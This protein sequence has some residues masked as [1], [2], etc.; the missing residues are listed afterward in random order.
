MSD[1][2]SWSR[3]KSEIYSLLGRNPKS[4]R[5]V[6]EIASLEPTHVVLDVGCGPGAAVR[7]AAGSVARAV[8]VDRSEPMIAIA[9]RRSEGF[10]NAEFVAAGAEE[11]PFPDA[12]FD[13]VWTIHAF[14]HWEDRS[15]GIA[16]CLRVLKPGG[17][18]LI[19]ESDTTSAHGLDQERA[20]EVAE[21]LRTAGFSSASVAKPG[22][23]LVVTG[24]SGD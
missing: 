15:R 3:L 10:A 1:T 22:K 23:Q 13:R 21:T 7:A 2:S 14:H 9:R 8:G 24:V 5:M 11:L 20:A 12:T 19:V 18:L 16:E 6:A 4:N 17:R